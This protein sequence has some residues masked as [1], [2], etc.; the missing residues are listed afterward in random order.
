MK[1]TSC[2]ALTSLLLLVSAFADDAR[3]DLRSP[4][5]ETNPLLRVLLYIAG[6]SRL[7]DYPDVYK[8]LSCDDDR[9]TFE[10][11]DGYV[12]THHGQ[13]TVIQQKAA[14]SEAHANPHGPRF[15]DVK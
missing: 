5:P 14:L 11:Q 2:A 7:I 12:V 9:I 13:F 15:F 3:P 6:S 8:I 4:K 10:T 1:T